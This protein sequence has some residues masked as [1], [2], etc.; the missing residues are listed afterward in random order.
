MSAI[1]KLLE[2]ARSRL[3]RPDPRRAAE[4]VTH[5][6]ILVDTRPG[7]QRDQEGDLPGAREVVKT[8]PKAVDPTQLVAAFASYYG[9]GWVLDDS[10]RDLLLR[11]LVIGAHGTGGEYGR[12]EW[13]E[14]D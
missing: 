2:T 14:R 5:G 3:D 10:Q 7:W 13:G 1:E 12:G 6:A 11:R 9:L 8:A 4:M